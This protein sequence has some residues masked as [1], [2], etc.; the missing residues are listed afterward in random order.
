MTPEHFEVTYRPD[1][2]WLHRKLD[3]KRYAQLLLYLVIG[4]FAL[5]AAVAATWPYLEA[6]RLGYRV[7]ELRL[8]RDQLQKDIER[9][10]LELSEL[11]NP[12]SVERIARETYGLEPAGERVILESP[13][14]P[15]DGR[16]DP[17]SPEAR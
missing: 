10:Q 13:D 3:R 17:G 7:E 4:I 2:H 12:S 15:A 6:I 5:T 11:T 8:E 14:A 16:P 9:Y 1:N